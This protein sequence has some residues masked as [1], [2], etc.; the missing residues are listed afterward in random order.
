MPGVESVHARVHASPCLL[1]SGGVVLQC[2][3]NLHVKG[4]IG[5][6]CILLTAQSFFRAMQPACLTLLS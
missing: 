4:F 6:C 2:D 1:T 5:I 3:M